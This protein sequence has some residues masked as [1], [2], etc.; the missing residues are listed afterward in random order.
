MGANSINDDDKNYE[1]QINAATA[2]TVEDWNSNYKSKNRRA[3]NGS[4]MTQDRLGYIKENRINF[5]AHAKQ[6]TLRQTI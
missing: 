4:L 2:R 3:R 6:H 1:L 5:T